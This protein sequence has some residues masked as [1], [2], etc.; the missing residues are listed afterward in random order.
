M[1]RVAI[2]Y[3]SRESIAYHVLTQSII[4]QTTAP[5]AITP[6]TA[7]S[8]QGFDGQR[9]GTNGF[10]YSRFLVPELM[11]FEGWAIYLDSDMLLRADLSDLW[12]LRDESKAVM[13]VK[14][15]YHTTH[16]RKLIGT[17]MECSNGDYPRKNWSSMVLWNCGHPANRHLTREFVAN[18]PGSV[19]HRFAWLPDDF[20]G[21][22][23]PEWNW[24]VGEYPLEAEAKLVHFTYGAPCFRHYSRCD[25]SGEWHAT[26]EEVNAALDNARLFGAA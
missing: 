23:D 12:S 21:E 8:L 20:I 25:Y 22:I 16:R 3:D 11:R 2:G 14:H 19:L 24:L 1:L 26:H 5:V 17:P 10:I 15:D 18:N 6:L 13:V 9:D 4:D 7:L